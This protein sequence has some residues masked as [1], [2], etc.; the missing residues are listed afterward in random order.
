M[1]FIEGSFFV[2]YRIGFDPCFDVWMKSILPIKRILLT[3]P[4]LCPAVTAVYF[5]QTLSSLRKPGHSCGLSR[6]PPI[7]ATPGL[8]GVPPSLVPCG[9]RYS[10]EYSEEVLGGRG[11]IGSSCYCPRS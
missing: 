8:G 1:V 9:P 10:E 5:Q 4:E 11:K 7:A 6:K 3:L 2:A